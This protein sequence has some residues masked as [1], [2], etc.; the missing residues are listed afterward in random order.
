MFEDAVEFDVHAGQN[1]R[2]DLVFDRCRKNDRLEGCRLGGQ[3]EGFMQSLE[4]GFRFGCA[5]HMELRHAG[6]QLVGHI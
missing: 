2:I 3:S 1:L 6:F 5:I 4:A